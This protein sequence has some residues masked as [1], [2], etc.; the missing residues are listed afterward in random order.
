M[1]IWHKAE[2]VR[3]GRYL[4]VRPAQGSG[5]WDKAIVSL[6]DLYKVESVRQGHCLT[7]KPAQG[8]PVGQGRC[9]T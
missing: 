5:L 9:L 2:S 7:V 3:Q 1:P 8:R 6:S 4:T